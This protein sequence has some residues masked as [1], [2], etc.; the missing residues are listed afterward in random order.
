MQPTTYDSHIERAQAAVGE[1]NKLAPM[2]TGFARAFTGNPLIRVVPKIGVTMTDGKFIYIEPPL[3]LA[4]NIEHDKALCNRHDGAMRAMCEACGLRESILFR[5]FHEIAHNWAGSFEAVPD[6]DKARAVTDAAK[7]MGIDVPQSTL[8]EIRDATLKG[9]PITYDAIARSISPF[10]DI[11]T[12]ALEDA[13]VNLKM[14]QA[15]PGFDRMRQGDEYETLY[16]GKA[17]LDPASGEERIMVFGDRSLDLQA[18]IGLYRKA[19]GY[20]VPPSAHPDVITALADERLDEVCVKAVTAPNVRGPYD[21]GVRALEILREYGLMGGEKKSDEEELPQPPSLPSEE[22]TDSNGDPEEGDDGGDQSEAEQSDRGDSESSEAEPSEAAPV[23]EDGADQSGDRDPAGPEGAS[24]GTDRDDEDSDEADGSE[25]SEG[26]GPSSGEPGDA[27]SDETLDDASGESDDEASTEGS[28]AAD[29]GQQDVPSTRSSADEDVDSDDE[30]DEAES[31]MGGEDDTADN[32]AGGQPG[33]DEGSDGE[34][35][36]QADASGDGS[37]GGQDGAGGG[38]EDEGP[39]SSDQAAGGSSPDESGEQGDPATGSESEGDA[40]QGESEG[41]SSGDAAESGSEV[42]T[43]ADV[44]DPGTGG[45]GDGA[46][47]SDP[48]DS[49]EHGDGGADDLGHDDGDGQPSG[50]ELV[51]S[52]GEADQDTD[53]DDPAGG[54]QSVSAAMQHG[55]HA[56]GGTTDADQSPDIDDVE[57][58]EEELSDDEGTGDPLDAGEFDSDWVPTTHDPSMRDDAPPVEVLT[59]DEVAQEMEDFFGHDHER[60]NDDEDEEAIQALVHVV[61]AGI[62]FDMIPRNVAGVRIH[63]YDKHVV[64]EW[65]D[66]YGSHHSH[67]WANGWTHDYLTRQRYRSW[68]TGISGDFR[69][70][71]KIIGAALTRARIVFANNARTKEI[72]NLKSGKVNA[73]VLGRR[74]PVKDPRLFAVKQRPGRRNYFVILGGDISL[75][76]LGTPI[77]MIKRAIMAQAELLNRLGIRFEVIMHSAD[78]A[79]G[80]YSNQRAN[81]Y[82]VDLYVVKDAGEP[83]N[84]AARKRLESIGPDSNNLDGHTIQLYRKRLDARTETDRILMYYTDG[85]MPALNATE[86]VEVLRRELKIFNQKDY[87]LLCV[88]VKTSSPE[89]WGLPTARVDSDVDLVKVIKHLEKALVQ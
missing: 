34:T 63:R 57:P 24:G 29:E 11:I 70:P 2:L 27:E 80:V 48:A 6:A 25:G 58:D 87:K 20:E 13:R 46:H 67:D 19:S 36:D 89:E 44:A 59:A 14:G 39:S 26:A 56:A 40:T 49:T 83:W 18:A 1:F 47:G 66:E 15:R 71:E 61:N 17:R 55:T 64:E 31:D 60:P 84:D 68:E 86:E 21:A 37:E 51:G 23:D 12:N 45:D 78:T 33:S 30:H 9:K 72:R 76:T 88:G 82:E 41:D 38:D 69:V 5:T 16:E 50:D 3:K 77:V 42:G 35:G 73:R 28:D 81:G 62:F 65:V 54:G 22:E 79:R 10:L 85:R 8:D 43:G 32:A 53:E 75:S 52:L 7:A 74:A 4:D